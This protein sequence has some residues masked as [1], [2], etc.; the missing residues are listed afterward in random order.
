MRVIVFLLVLANLAFFAWAQGY[1]GAH[2]N[3]DAIRLG[4][5]VAADRLI[6]LS[7]DEPPQPKAVVVE[8]KPVVEKCLAW[9][10]LAA[11]DADGIEQLLGERFPGLRRSRHTIPESGSWWVYIPPL[12]SKAEADR[13][14]AELK[15]LGAPEFFVVQ[16]KGPNRLAISLG[17]FSSEQAAKERL[18]ALQAKGVRSAKVAR[19]ATA[20]EESL[21]IEGTGPEA[22]L[23]AAREAVQQQLP[24]LKTTSCGKP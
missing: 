21:S 18:D 6:V 7:H 4:Q 20:T 23:D 12:A 17:I 22:M 2:E 13:K 16:D 9:N 1:L 19:R 15:R 24:D 3:P 10:A 11:A 8:K 5:Q 14:S